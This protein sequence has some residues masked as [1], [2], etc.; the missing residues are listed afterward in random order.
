MM[1]P[2]LEIKYLRLAQQK[3]VYLAEAK[4]A[5]QRQLA[6]SPNPGKWSLLEL[7]DHLVLVES[8]ALRFMKSFDFN[9]SDKKTNVRSR[10]N[11]LLL[12]LFLSS[13]IK[14]K[15]PVPTV[16]PKQKTLEVLL[17]EWDAQNEELVKFLSGFPEE[18]LHNFIFVHPVAGKFNILQTL[19]F[20]VD[21]LVHHQLQLK[22]I[23]AHAGFQAC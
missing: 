7:L 1:H 14:F 15:V 4:N 16:I 8:Q 20:L 19:D 10:I 21:H 5:N 6:F 12:R 13:R 11:S 9:R 23:R 22:A 3:A 17:V 2:K 18:K